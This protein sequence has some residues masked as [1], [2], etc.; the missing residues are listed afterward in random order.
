MK[1]HQ[2]LSQSLR[3]DISTCK[4]DFAPDQLKTSTDDSELSEIQKLLYSVEA[5]VEKIITPTLKLH[6][7]RI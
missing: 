5:Y 3:Y 6:D 4:G 1:P 2:A 7:S